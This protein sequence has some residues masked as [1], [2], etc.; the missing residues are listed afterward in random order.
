MVAVRR[1]DTDQ[2]GLAAASPAA[3]Q[4][5][6]GGQRGDVDHDLVPVIPFLS[7]EGARFM[8]GQ[9]FGSPGL[10]RDPRITTTGK[11]VTLNV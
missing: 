3:L 5:L 11:A 4:R 9:V 2:P 8:S 10:R 7:G 6:R 1:R